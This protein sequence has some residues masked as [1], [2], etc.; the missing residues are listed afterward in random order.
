MDFSQ[1]WALV[2][3][4]IPAGPM[5][6][7]QYVLVAIGGLGVAGMVVVKLTPSKA[8]DE[9]VNKALELPVLGAFLKFLISFSPIKP[10]E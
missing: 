4:F 3:G 9:A 7:V 2:S 8:D 1:V 6:V 10:K 5:E